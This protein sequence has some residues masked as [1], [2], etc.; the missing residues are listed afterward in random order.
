MTYSALLFPTHFVIPSL[1]GQLG[2]QMFQIAAATSLALDH[3]A[4][5]LVPDLNESQKFGIPE[6]RKYI[7]YKVNSAHP[8][9]KVKYEYKEPYFHY[10]KITYRPNMKIHGYFQSE[11]YFAHHKEKIIR[12]FSPSKELT[13]YLHAKYPDIIN[14]PNS[15]AIHVR[16]Y[17]KE[18]PTHRY[19]HLNGSEYISKAMNYF[20]KGSLFIV[21]SDDI[22]WCKSNLDFSGRQVRFIEDEFYIY[23]FYLM[24]L[25]KHNI[26]SNSS[27]SWWA[28]YLNSNPKKIVIAP[29]Q[30]FSSKAKINSKD[31]IPKTWITLK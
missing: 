13:E 10:K 23:D 11:K 4:Q 12:I 22:Q 30:W 16:T 17:N 25:C 20:P 21:C 5:V 29:S 7:F 6:N 15:V 19:H 1:K 18:D 2:N 14:H 9:Q 24:S 28:A 8:P 26:I 31:L 3:H 27:F